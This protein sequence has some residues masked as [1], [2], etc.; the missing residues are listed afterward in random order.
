MCYSTVCF[1]YNFCAITLYLHFKKCA[2][3]MLME[4][5][6]TLK[7]KVKKYHFKDFIGK[8]PFYS[9]YQQTFELTV[10]PLVVLVFDKT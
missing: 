8:E 2:T 6:N 4:Y 1:K 5:F 3:V 9:K 7:N 10:V